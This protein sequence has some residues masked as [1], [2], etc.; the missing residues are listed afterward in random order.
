MGAN[1]GNH[2]VVRPHNPPDIVQQ[3]LRLHRKGNILPPLLVL[4]HQHLLNLQRL[5]RLL[6]GYTFKCQP[7]QGIADIPHHLR[8]RLIELIDM[9]GTGINV[10]NLPVS[11]PVPFHRGQLYNIV[12]H[13]NHQVRLLQ[14]Q[15]GVILLGNSHRPHGIR[16]FPGNHS[17]G[18]HGVHHGNFQLN[19]KFRQRLRCPRP[20]SGM[21]HQHHRLSGSGNLRRRLLQNILLRALPAGNGTV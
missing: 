12:P 15:V 8:I 7:Q 4:L 21:S 11:V 5:L 20:D 13:G 17:L 3:L 9:G 2:N 6:L 19:G 1:I 16:I 14:N 10:K 18:H